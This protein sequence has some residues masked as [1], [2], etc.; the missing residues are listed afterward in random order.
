MPQGPVD[1]VDGGT[2]RINRR[3]M[4]SRLGHRIDLVDASGKEAVRVATT[5]EKLKL[6]MDHTGTT[7]TLHADGKVS[8]EGTQGITIDSSSANIDLKGN[9]ISLKATSG[10]TVDGG[11]GAVDVKSGSQLSLTGVTAKL[12]G[13]GT[14]EVK[15]GSMCSIQGAMVKIN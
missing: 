9:Q 6:I 4:V 5:D 10:V 8:I 11:S 7:I 3:S 1:L 13:S 2:G 14:T 12:E 15:G